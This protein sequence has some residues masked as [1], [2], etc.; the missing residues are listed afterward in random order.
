MFL[1]NNKLYK[2]VDGVAMGSPLGPSLANF[3]L[4]HL[5]DK[6][7]FNSDECVWGNINPKLYIRYVD[8]VFAVF[9][10]KTP[11]NNFL[12]HLNSQHRNIKFTVEEGI[13]SLPFL[14]TEIR[15]NGDIFESWTYRKKTDTGVI[16]NSA[17]VCPQIWKKSLIFGALNRAKVVCSNIE[18]FSNEVDKLKKIFWNNGYSY[19]FF[20]KILESFENKTALNKSC[21]LDFDKRYFVK[22]PYI[23]PSSHDFKNKI[24]K[25]F[26]NYLLTN[27]SPIFSTFKVANYF[28]L[29][30][31][32]PKILASNV[33]Y[34]FSCLCATNLTYIGKTK[35]HLTVRG[36]EHLE[37]EKAEP[38]SEIKEHLKKCLVCRKSNLDNFEILK[39]CKSDFEAKVTEAL[40]IKKENPTLNKQLFNS[41]SLYTLKVYF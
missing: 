2:Q 26:S 27:V 6:F 34:K 37:F 13:G 4:G 7:F 8:D 36:L 18:L 25:L 3:F 1:Y 23:G 28:S 22:I 14:D 5:E 41:G 11:F 35:R 24:T 33:V 19:S 32:T 20:Q 21:D 38:K 10:N 17:A 39:K 15:I 31:Q 9:D 12:E 30:S 40:Y 16:L 29:K